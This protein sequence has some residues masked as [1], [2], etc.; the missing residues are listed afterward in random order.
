MTRRSGRSL[1]YIDF[2]KF[3]EAEI[4]GGIKL[5]NCIELGLGVLDA[6]TVRTIVLTY[7]CKRNNRDQALTN[8]ANL[9]NNE[10]REKTLLE[11]S[12]YST[13]LELR[14]VVEFE[15]LPGMP[16]LFSMSKDFIRYL[17]QVQK[18]N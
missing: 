2:F 10:N 3:R 14:N 18:L 8:S 6:A 1:Y 4:F 5:A 9:T 16:I 12:K 7:S 17:N 15:G 11:F 13:G